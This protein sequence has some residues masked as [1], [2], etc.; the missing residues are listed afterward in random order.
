MC[1]VWCTTQAVTLLAVTS[2]EWWRM[3]WVSAGGY[4]ER[5]Y[6]GGGPAAGVQDAHGALRVPPELQS[7]LLLLQ[8]HQQQGQGMGQ[9]MGGLA[10]GAGGPPG[11]GRLGP[12]RLMDRQVERPAPMDRPIERPPPRMDAPSRCPQPA[13]NNHADLMVA[14]DSSLRM[15][16]HVLASALLLV[17]WL[18]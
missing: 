18:S 12:D 2:S 6:D 13:G 10:P 5:R 11:A 17:D 7:Q 16:S 8:Q 9:G 14:A 3:V 15:S 4:D 1:A